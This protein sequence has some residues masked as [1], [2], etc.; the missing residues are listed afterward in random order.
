[1]WLKI[2]LLFFTNHLKLDHSFVL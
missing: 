1:M 2:L